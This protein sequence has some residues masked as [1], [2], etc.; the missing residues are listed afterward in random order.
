MSLSGFP[1]QYQSVPNHVVLIDE[2]ELV[3]AKMGS[4]AEG[5][6]DTEVG[7]Q[8]QSLLCFYD[9]VEFILKGQFTQIKKHSL[10]K[11]TL[12]QQFLGLLCVYFL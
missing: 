1:R 6:R 11:V 12:C 9:E 4:L 8:P 3:V 5:R 7:L 2:K 10:I